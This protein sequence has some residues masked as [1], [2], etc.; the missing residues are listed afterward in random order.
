MQMIEYRCQQTKL[1]GRRCNA[2]IFKGW[3]AG[4]I[5]VK[6]RRCGG[7]TS[8]D[9]IDGSLQAMCEMWQA[10]GVISLPSGLHTR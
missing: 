7:Y 10:S 8:W 6:C 9:T 2:L 1:D 4:Q 3:F 5:E